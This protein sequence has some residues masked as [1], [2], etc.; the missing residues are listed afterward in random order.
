MERLE[1]ES[2]LVVIGRQLR[3]ITQQLRAE[4]ITDKYAIYSEAIK[5][6]AAEGHDLTRYDE[7]GPHATFMFE[8]ETGNLTIIEGIILGA[9]VAPEEMIGVDLFTS[10]GICFGEINADGELGFPKSNIEPLTPDEFG[11]LP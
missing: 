10:Q 1:R 4:G 7:G 3:E 9:D 8:P 5:R 11:T 6:L 2:E